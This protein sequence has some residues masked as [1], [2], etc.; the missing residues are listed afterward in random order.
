MSRLASSRSLATV[1]PS[2]LRTV[3]WPAGALELPTLAMAGTVF[4]FAVQAAQQLRVDPGTAT[5][6][7]N[8]G[9]TP[10][11]YKWADAIGE[12]MGVVYNGA[13][14]QVVAKRGTWN[15]EA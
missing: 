4:T 7:D 13:N 9:Q 1:S 12:C 8:S 14:W 3:V 11:K 10:D 5:I 6:R 15:E 2:T